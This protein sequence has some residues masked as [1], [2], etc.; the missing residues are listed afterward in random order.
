MQR[1]N[2]SLDKGIHRTPTLGEDGELS[3][4]VNMI[5]RNGQLVPIRDCTASFSYSDTS[6]TLLYVHINSGYRHYLHARSVA[7][8]GQ[9]AAHVELY[10]SDATSGEPTSPFT[11]DPSSKIQGIELPSLEDLYKVVSIGDT[12]ILSIS[13]GLKM[14]VYRPNA[15]KYDIVEGTIPELN[16]SFGLQTEVDKIASDFP[17]GRFPYM[18]FVDR[19]KDE[20]N[21]FGDNVK[22]SDFSEIIA[23][24]NRIVSEAIADNYFLFPFF[25]RYAMT[26]KDGTLVHVSP[27]VLMTPSTSNPTIAANSTIIPQTDHSDATFGTPYIHLAKSRLDMKVLEDEIDALEAFKDIIDRV[28]VYVSPQFYT[29]DQSGDFTHCRFAWI[30]EDDFPSHINSIK[31]GYSYG[32]NKG[33]DDSD[34]IGYQRIPIEAQMSLFHSD[35]LHENTVIF[36]N[37]QRN[38]ED[39]IRYNNEYYLLDSFTLEQLRGFEDERKVISISKNRL[40]II[41]SFKRLEEIRELRDVFKASTSFVYNRRLN[42]AGVERKPSNPLSALSLI[43]YCD[44]EGASFT[45]APSGSGSDRVIACTLDSSGITDAYDCVQE[46]RYTN[47]YRDITVANTKAGALALSGNFYYLAVPSDYASRIWMHGNTQGFA[48]G[49]G[50][51]LKSH[52]LIYASYWFE[53]IDKVETAVIM[54]PPETSQEWYAE[55]EIYQS[56]PDDPWIF[57]EALKYTVGNGTIIGLT[58]MSKPM[59]TGQYGQFPFVV[60]S[61]DGIWTMQIRDDGTFQPAVFVSGDICSNPSSI[62]QTDNAVLFVTKQGLKMIAGSDVRLL[63]RVIEGVNISDDSFIPQSPWSEIVIPDIED[64]RNI[65]QSCKIVYDYID[66]LVHIFNSDDDGA[67]GKHDCLSLESFEFATE[68]QLIPSGNTSAKLGQPKVVIPGYPATLFQVGTSIYSYKGYDA[69]PAA[70]LGYLITRPMAFGEFTQF[71]TIMDLRL[72][73]DIQPTPAGASAQNGAWVILHGSN[74]KNNWHELHSVKGT[75]F[76]YYRIAVVSRLGKDDTIS[77]ISLEYED[78]RGRKMK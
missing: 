55:N 75:P 3:E 35:A 66:N 32:Y 8:S 28:E 39:D 16:L 31:Q 67:V 46:T 69:D 43:N 10:W 40:S 21:E 74:D 68:V 6:W 5:P 71:K 51:E 26:M 27:P 47:K 48:Y 9:T 22:T 50:L 62:T 37:P 77:G 63:S 18:K 25:V 2:I 41:S 12:L 23:D 73:S 49:M 7:A 60:F 15:S 44:K 53:G 58:S 64:K 17:A 72:Y 38:F 54:T 13:T 14:C 45:F 19:S 78:R 70:K 30:V 34:T 29:Y 24:R 56:L 11:P 1:K 65:L 42:I 4:L 52:D 61:S 20:W 76:K 36:Q 57:P 33:I 59:S